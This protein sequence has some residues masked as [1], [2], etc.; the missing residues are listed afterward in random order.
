MHSE[1]ATPPSPSYEHTTPI[2]FT[3]KATEFFG[4]WITNIVLSMLTLGIYSAWGKVRTKK[5]FN[6]H[7]VIAGACFDYHGNPLSIL[8]GRVIGVVL[9]FVYAM[10]SQFAPLFALALLAILF[11][12]SPWIIVQSM[13]FNLRNTSYRGVRFNFVGSLAESYKIFLLLPFLVIFTVGLILPYI[14]FRAYKFS[15]NNTRFGTASFLSTVTAGRFYMIYLQLIGVFVA[16]AVIIGLL[17][18]VMQKIVGNLDPVV[19]ISLL[20]LMLLIFMIA[21]PKALLSARIY[22]AVYGTTQIENFRF[23]SAL[24]ARDLFW[25]YLS[26]FI[27]IMF[28]FGLM[29]PWTKIRLARYMAD[30]LVIHGDADFNHFVGE[31]IGQLSA[32]GQE[33]GD[34]F[35]VEIPVL[36]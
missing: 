34:I 31:R 36:G 9:Y 25:I 35:D 29:I 10:V 21:V 22:N 5:Y 23:K 19:M 6:T 30:H 7:T 12:A 14:N 13:K 15:I 33:I 16:F 11:I 26:N 18:F 3:G 32:T 17:S 4:I 24:R 2:K 8:K 1:S 27:V 28:S 20:P